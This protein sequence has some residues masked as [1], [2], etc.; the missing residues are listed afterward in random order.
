MAKKKRKKKRRSRSGKSVSLQSKERTYQSGLSHFREGEYELA[1]RAWSGIVKGS[2]PR[3]AAQLAEAHFR[4][5]IS[6]DRS[7]NMKAVISEL[8]S[9]LKYGVHNEPSTCH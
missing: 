4:N 3:L 8:H 9:A 5:A 6:K 7:G 1:I 2:G